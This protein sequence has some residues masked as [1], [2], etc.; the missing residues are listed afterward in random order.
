[1]I[2]DVVIVWGDIL[3]CNG[4]RAVVSYRCGGATGTSGAGIRAGV[5]RQVHAQ[6][7]GDAVSDVALGGIAASSIGI[8]DGVPR[9]QGSAATL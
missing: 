6:A 5:S 1:V 3:I 2:A 4:G 9:G 7:G 8:G